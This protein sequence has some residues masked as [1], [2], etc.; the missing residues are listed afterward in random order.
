MK[1]DFIADSFVQKNDLSQ[2]QLSEHYGRLHMTWADGSH[3]NLTVTDT[4]GVL[5]YVIDG[6]IA[7]RAISLRYQRTIHKEQFFSCG[8]TGELG[9]KGVRLDDHDLWF[10]TKAKVYV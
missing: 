3:A 5:L 10:M 6:M 8:T 4:E 7:D 1:L 9:S 2:P